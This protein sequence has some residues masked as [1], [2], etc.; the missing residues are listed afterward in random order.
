M[1]HEFVN[2]SVDTFNLNHSLVFC[3]QYEAQTSF[4]SIY[5]TRIE[6]NSMFCD[7]YNSQQK[8]YCKRLKVLCPEHSKEPKVS[9][10]LLT[11]WQSRCRTGMNTQEKIRWRLPSSSGIEKAMFHL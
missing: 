7:Y 4:G 11:D 5:K 9:K 1:K 8:T 2:L 10:L 3:L 6:G